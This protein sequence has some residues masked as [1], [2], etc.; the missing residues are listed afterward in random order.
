MATVK[1]CFF[2][3]LFTAREVISEQYRVVS[4][5]VLSQG[6]IWNENGNKLRQEYSKLYTWISYKSKVTLS[7]TVF[8]VRRN[9]LLYGHD[10]LLCIR[11]DE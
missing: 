6:F 10:E 4:W 8:T 11:I 3:Q 5:L 7:V 2:I 1:N 9:P